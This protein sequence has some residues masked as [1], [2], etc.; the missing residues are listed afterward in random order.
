MDI[1]KKSN[2][3]K[4]NGIK[5]RKNKSKEIEVINNSNKKGYIIFLKL[6]DSHKMK[7]IVSKINVVSGKQPEIKILSKKLKVIESVDFNCDTYLEIEHSK[8]FIGLTIS[9]GT[10]FI[11]KELKYEIDTKEDYIETNFKGEILLISPGYPTDNDRYNCAFIHPRVQAYKKEGYNIDVAVVNELYINKTVKDKYEGINI[12]KTGYND[13][14]KLLQVKKYKKILIHFFNEKYAQILD[15]SDINETN[16]YLFLHGSDTMYWDWPKMSAKYFEQKAEISPELLKTFKERD[17]IIK[18]YNEKE[19]VKWVFVADYTKVNSEKLLNIKFKNSCVIPCNIDE[20]AFQYEEKDAEQRKKICMIRKFHNVNTYSIDINVRTI[21]ELSKRPY[22]KDLE[23]SIYG[24]GE[25]H[26]VLLEPL[27]QFENVHIFKRFLSHDEMGKMY[28]ENGIALFATRYDSQAVASL[29]AAISGCVVLTS[30]NV[31]VTQFIDEK[32]GTYCETE[33]FK[34]YADMIEEM[35]YNPEIFLRKSKQMHKSI[36]ATC[37]YDKTIKK[38]LELLREPTIIKEEKYPKAQKQPLLTIAIP[39]YNVEKFLNVAVKSLINNNPYVDKLEILIIDDGSID[40]TAEIGKKLE[41]L[42]TVE[43]SS[44]VKIITKKNG[45]H[46]STINEGIKLAKGKYFRLMDGDDYFIT[47]EFVKLLRIL[48]TED[49]DIILTIYIADYAISGYKEV[50]CGYEFMVPGIKYDLDF[51]HYEGYGFENWGPLLSTATYKTENLKKANFKIDEKCFYV[52]MEYNYMGYT[53]SK[54]VVYYPFNIYN[55]YLGRAG[56][57][58]SKEGFKKN[59]YHHETVCL[60]LIKEYEKDKDNLTEGKKNYILN[61]LIIPIAKM[62]YDIAI[63][64]F[65]TKKQFISYD[66]KLKKYPD[67]YNMT[68]IAGKRVK[69][70]RKTKGYLIKIDLLIKVIIKIIKR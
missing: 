67:F 64:Y 40:K 45:G 43:N 69:L 3:I 34:E 63:E 18:R 14:R 47:K 55:Y 1:L 56:Q 65:N 36:K 30:K 11:L 42:T 25:M 54:N 6:I 15:A 37:N 16:I 10:H 29:E 7:K 20:N 57:S 70:H 59:W 33:D 44:I 31:G 60:R 27:K 50:M 13:I 9:P 58:N 32:I 28:R 19:N 46:G 5:I 41:K 21:L 53:N 17:E 23:F 22:F 51:M 61:R 24:D 62:Q 12:T 68:A 38:D 35:Y 66:E 48:E 2:L 4:T 39:S 52:D 8:V 49:T 26:D